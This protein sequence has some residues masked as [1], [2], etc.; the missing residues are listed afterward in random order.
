M[1]DATQVD[2]PQTNEPMTDATEAQ[3]GPIVIG[4]D[5]IDAENQVIFLF[6]PIKFLIFVSG[7][8]FIG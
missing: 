1:N 2:E 8:Y 5:S 6:F 4:D 7:I 3:N